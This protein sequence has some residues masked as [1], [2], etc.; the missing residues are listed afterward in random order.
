MKGG[1][2][3]K[4]PLGTSGAQPC[5]EVPGNSLRTHLRLSYLLK[6]EAGLI[7]HHWLSPL[8]H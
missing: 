7:V 8:Y 3:R 2:S 4:V 6:E 5:G 1:T